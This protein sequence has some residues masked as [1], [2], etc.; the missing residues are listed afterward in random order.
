MHGK[1]Q[2]LVAETARIKEIYEK[3]VN[4]TDDVYVTLED[5]SKK[6]LKD[7][8]GVGDY[9]AYNVTE[10]VEDQSKLTYESP[11]GTGMSHGNGHSAQTFTANDNIRWRVLN[12]DYTSGEVTLI[13]ETPLQ[14]DAGQDFYLSGAIGYLYAEQELNEICKIYGYGKGANTAKTFE[15]DTGDV[16][17]GL[18]KGTIVGSG[19]RSINVDDINKI[20]GYDPTKD[21][22]IKDTYLKEY[23]H[24][25]FYPTKTTESGVSQTAENR[26]DIN[27]IYTYM[28]SNCIDTTDIKYEL[29]I[30][31]IENSSNIS[32]WLASQGSIA[33]ETIKDF[34]IRAIRDGYLG[35]G[36]FGECDNKGIHDRNLNSFKI[37]PIVYLKANL[38][39]T[40]KDENGAWVISEE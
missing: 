22:T 3:D 17:E 26:T 24:T 18:D 23:T 15:Y 37:R 40:G 35:Y 19:A 33:N 21:D 14:T 12:I 29:L 25:I 11:V 38:R 10:G 30:K 5:N 2:T 8:V 9:V 34:N 28:V 36:Y 20:T 39:T 31:S 32:Y 4:N 13:S 16:V 1:E 27:N 6:Y 7:V